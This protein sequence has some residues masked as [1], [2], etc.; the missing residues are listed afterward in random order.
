MSTEA[1]LAHHLQAFAE[2]IE[3]ILSDYTEESILFTPNG[4]IRGLDELRTFFEGFIKNSPPEL[5]E[6]LKFLR[7]DIEGEVA[8]TVWK[9][10]P[11]I[12]MATDTFVVRE[13]KILVQTVATLS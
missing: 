11:Y 10:E 7:Q 12:K 2:G 8:Y 1:T 5:F 3:A 6:A 13:G 4:V 9:A